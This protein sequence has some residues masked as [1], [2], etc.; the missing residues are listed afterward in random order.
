MD[1][2]ILS[3]IFF[4]FFAAAPHYKLNAL[5]PHESSSSFEGIRNL[6]KSYGN[7]TTH[8]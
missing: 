8:F 4:F 6:T 3:M 5:L 1:L 2:D 7:D